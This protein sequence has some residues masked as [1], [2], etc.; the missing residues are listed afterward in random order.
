MR[1]NWQI[2]IASLEQNTG[3]VCNHLLSPSQPPVTAGVSTG[4]RVFSRV[5]RENSLP[6]SRRVTIYWYV[7]VLL[8]K[9]GQ[10]L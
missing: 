1:T 3:Q 7:F 6:A 10:L 4:T 8:R 5:L 2:G 9:G